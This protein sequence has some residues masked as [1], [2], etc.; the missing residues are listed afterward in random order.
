MGVGKSLGK[1]VFLRSFAKSG[2]ED[3]PEICVRDSA[4]KVKMVYLQ[5][6]IVDVLF[7]IFDRRGDD[8]EFVPVVVGIF[9]A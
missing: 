1:N 2:G 5:V 8:S 4:E 3:L 7:Q 6:A 9:L